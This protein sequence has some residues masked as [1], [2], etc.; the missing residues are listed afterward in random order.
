MQGNDFLHKVFGHNNVRQHKEFKCWFSCQDPRKSIPTR[1]LY[2]NWKLY[3][4]LK[5]ILYV[6]HFARLIGCDLAVDEQTSY[7][8]VD[9]CIRWEYPTRTRGTD[10][11]WMLY[12]TGDILM[13]FLEELMFSKGIQ[14]NG[15]STFTLFY[16]SL[17][18][19]L[20]NTFH[21]SHLDNLYMSAEFSYLSYTHHNCVK[22]QGVCQIGDWL[23]PRELL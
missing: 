1:K 9:I 10:F 22:V 12:A 20:Q 4:F 17:F 6:F 16:F 21:E 3:P 11:R 5:H 7:S 13:I 23:I 8:K 14:I 15:T 18:L 2:P 19:T